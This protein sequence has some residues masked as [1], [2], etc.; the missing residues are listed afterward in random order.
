MFGYIIIT[1]FFIDDVK[2]AKKGI[3][4]ACKLDLRDFKETLYGDDKQKHTV[5]VRSL[6]LNIDKKMTRTTLRKYGLTD[7]HVK[8][9]V[10]SDRITCEPIK[11]NGTVV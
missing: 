10:Q 11:E 7:I 3:P 6:K 5:E 2:E 8:L 9:A 1:T 4:H